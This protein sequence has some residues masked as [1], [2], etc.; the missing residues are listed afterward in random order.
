MC[1]HVLCRQHCQS[2]VSL[3]Q[4]LHVCH[5]RHVHHLQW[6]DSLYLGAAHGVA[7]VLYVLLHCMDVVDDLDR[8]SSTSGH[9][10]QYRQSVVE[11]VQ[12]LIGAMFPTGNLPSSVGKEADRYLGGHQ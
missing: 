11:A 8:S 4:T 12:S 7:G 10:P 2:A 9:Q 6:H 5:V 3:L 1:R